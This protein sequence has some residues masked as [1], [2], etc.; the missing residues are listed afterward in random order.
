LN[1][2]LNP[3]EYDGEALAKLSE[4]EKN[5]RDTGKRQGESAVEV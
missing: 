4:K 5:Q 1:D 2:K 3:A